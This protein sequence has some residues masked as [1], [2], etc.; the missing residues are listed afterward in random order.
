MSTAL[1]IF[2]STTG[3]T[4]SVAETIKRDLS[5]ADY[6]VKIINVADVD[7]DILN[8]AFDLYLL[9][10]STWG[11]DEIEFQEDFVSFYEN[12]NGDIKLSG[13]KF[14]VFGCGDSSYQYFCGAVDALEERLGKLGATLVCESLRID[15]EPDESDV[16]EWTQDVI[17]AA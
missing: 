10:S 4:E 1:I 7:V 5:K 8:E 14:A 2:G 13:K 3:N 12:M 16:N 9:G 6:T 11:D 15:G 17:N